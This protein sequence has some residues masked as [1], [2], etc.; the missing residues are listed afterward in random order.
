MRLYFTHHGA[1]TLACIVAAH[2]CLTNPFALSAQITSTWQGSSVAIWNDPSSWTAGVPMLAGDHAIFGPAI[3]TAPSNGFVTDP[4]TALGTLTYDNPFQF[5]LATT[6]PMAFDGNGGPALIDILDGQL[7]FSQGDFVL[8][9]DLNLSVASGSSVI[10]GLQPAPTAFLSGAGDLNIFGGG[11]VHLNGANTYSGVT[12]IT[13][14]TVRVQD[15][16]SLGAGTGTDLDGTVIHTGG[17]LEIA[18]NSLTLPDEKITLD[19]GTLTGGPTTGQDWT[20]SG[21]IQLNT[22][23]VTGRNWTTTG[24]LNVSNGSLSGSQWKVQGPVNITG[25]LTAAGGLGVI[26]TSI[27]GTGGLRLDTT[28]I[29]LFLNK[30]NSYTGITTVQDGRL[31]VSDDLALGAGTGTDADGTVVHPDGSLFIGSGRNIVNEKISLLGGSL[32]GTNFQSAG[33]LVSDAGTIKTTGST[34][35]GS[36]QLTGD[37]TLNGG[38]GNIINANI[39]GPGK[40]LVKAGQTTLTGTNTYTGQTVIEDGATL[41]IRSDAALGSGSAT[42]TDAIIINAG[43]ILN[44]VAVTLANEKIILNGGTLGRSADAGSA[45]SPININGPIELTA[46][47]TIHG[48]DTSNA[49][50]NIN[51]TISGT[52][53]LRIGS[54]T[55]NGSN[56]YTGTT[57]IIEDEFLFSSGVGSGSAIAN[58]PNSFGLVPNKLTL[59]G[60]SLFIEAPITVSELIVDGGGLNGSHILTVNQTNL[61]V[62]SGMIF[63]SET[64]GL[65]GVTQITKKTDGLFTLG[66]IGNQPDPAIHVERGVFWHRLN[67]RTYSAPITVAQRHAVYG[68]FE[69]TISSDINLLNSTGYAFGG[70][71]QS[72]SDFSDITGRV[73]LGDVGSIL[74]AGRAQLKLSGDVTGGA[75]TLSRGELILP[76]TTVSYT[77]RTTIALDGERTKLVLKD[78]G[79]LTAT[80][81]IVV[82]RGGTLLT[83]N[84]QIGDSIPIV[85]AGGILQVDKGTQDVTTETLGHVTMSGGDSIL[86]VNSWLETQPTS[87][88]INTFERQRGAVVIFSEQGFGELGGAS[89]G[90]PRIIL[91]PTPALTNGIIGGWASVV[92]NSAE[93]DFATYDLV[94][95]RGVRALDSAG[96]PDQVEGAAA[97]DNVR[98][99]G[100]PTAITEDTT[101]NSLVWN[102]ASSTPLDLG[103][104]TFNVVSGGVLRTSGTLDITNGSLTAG[105]SQPDAELFFIDAAANPINITANI[106]D[107]QAGAVSLVK[108]SSATLTLQGNNTY[109][110]STTVNNGVLRFLTSGSVPANT[111]LTLN[112]GDVRFDFEPGTPIPLGTVRLRHIGILATHVSGSTVSI[113]ADEYLIDSG[114]IDIPLSGQG[115]LTKNT[116]GRLDF[117][118]DNPNFSGDVLINNGLVSLGLET[119]LGSSHITLNGG[120]LEIVAPTASNTFTL[121]GGELASSRGPGNSLSPLVIQG[122]INVTANSSLILYAQP[123]ARDDTR[124]F[125]VDAFDTHLTMTGP[126]S[127]DSGVT[128]SRIGAG[129]LRITGDLGVGQSS[130]LDLVDGLTQIQGVIH[131][132]DPISSFDLSG[133]GQVDLQASLHVVSGRRLNISRDNL[134]FDFSVSGNG[135][136]VTGNGTLANNLVLGP[137]ATLMPGASAGTFTIDGDYTQLSDA[138][139]EIELGGAATG[140]HDQ[141][142]VTGELNPGGTLELLLIGGFAPTGGELFDILDFAT[143]TPG[144]LFDSFLFPQLAPG[145][146]WDTSNLL[147]TG[148]IR[149]A[150][151][152]STSLIILTTAGLLLRRT[153]G[154]G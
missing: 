78:Q 63:F 147:V 89:P 118:A 25:E 46:D 112:G 14:A 114:I 98:V 71:L 87:L 95:G 53:N 130:R 73:D 20:L 80:S 121:A 34:L 104:H 92:S 111:D 133:P 27:A 97:T 62:S 45:V 12:N 117:G 146:S 116:F 47:S 15:N 72:F 79:Q 107:N 83:H 90:D 119:T 101:I 82:N 29:G 22:G 148:E 122:G 1:R 103:G 42:N 19:G 145:L 149:V 33:P 31:L 37:L 75:L 32:E 105:G 77:G 69:G 153:K 151:E 3:P 91:S 59:E 64:G 74:A 36:I 2:L 141:L 68:T 123:N 13:N 66:F 113:D 134:P 41:V 154:R 136:T 49:K 55:L 129:T 86:R 30:P 35:N 93:I 124:L 135:K 17:T 126:I 150:P 139:L 84:E 21:P 110:G 142:V 40:F 5:G 10:V 54:A 88:V 44:P 24:P 38:A 81:E 39:S 43:G 9:T 127:I 28:G 140:L 16:H 152:P 18:S 143:I 48:Q 65:D 94:S 99:I 50:I 102:T 115:T 52:G 67:E 100:Q 106:V 57:T 131:A 96:R 51:G 61:P 23:L 76:S 70:V 108:S 125:I 128:L 60:G 109:T 58:H 8:A 7:Q 4:N 56:T 144:S 120:R 137:G 138:I 6:T 11:T 132:N 85:M 26:D